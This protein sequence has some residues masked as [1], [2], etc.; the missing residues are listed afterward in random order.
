MK[1]KMEVQVA[2]LEQQFAERIHSITGEDI[3]IMST[4]DYLCK[5]ESDTETVSY[6][7]EMTH[8]LNDKIAAEMKKGNT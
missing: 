1:V 7:S 6:E 2:E 3:P 4:N 5:G 8:K